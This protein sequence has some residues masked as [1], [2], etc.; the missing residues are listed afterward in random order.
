MKLASNNHSALDLTGREKVWTKE[1]ESSRRSSLSSAVLRMHSARSLHLEGGAALS[2]LAEIS[3]S[4]LAVLVYIQ[5]IAATEST[6]ATYI[7]VRTSVANIRL[8]LEQKL[9]VLLFFQ[10]SFFHT[11]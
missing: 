8:L 1:R 3:V 5:C 10:P 9:P 2:A 7:A 4:N 6:V 11:S